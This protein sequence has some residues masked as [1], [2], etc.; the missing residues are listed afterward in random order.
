MRRDVIAWMNDTPT[1]K[2]PTKETLNHRALVELVSGPDAYANTPE[3]YLRAYEALGIDIVNRVPLENAPA[4]TLEGQTRNHPAKPYH[5]GRLGIY[6]TVMRHTYPCKTPEEVWDLDVDAL[7]YGDLLNGVPHPCTGDDIRARETALGEIGAY[8]P[9]LYT[10][11]FMWGVEALGWEVFLMAAA[12]EPDRF[13][14]RF[15]APCAKKSAAIV[16]E[17]AE[18]TTLPFVFTHD[19]LAAG[20]GPMFAPSWYDEY[21]FPQYDMIYAGARRLGKRIVL[22]AD[23]NMTA[24]LP[25]LVEAGIDGI[26]FETPATPLEAVVEHFGAPGRF[27]IGGIATGKLAFGTP[28]EVRKMVHD[29]YAKAGD[30]PGFALASSGGLHDDIPMQNIAAYFDARVEIGATPQDWRT[31][32]RA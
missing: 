30:C 29:V 27:F 7:T 26:M 4:P 20:T 11:L 2:L 8:Y 31:R 10:T 24:F 32:C 22:V 5:Y 9:M 6:D 12:L 1:A 18:A 3:A 25:K 17:M 23:G 15:L 14:E 16:T 28:D 19:D 21:I 13:F